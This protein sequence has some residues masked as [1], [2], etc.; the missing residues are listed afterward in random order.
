MAKKAQ[1]GEVNKS[2]AIRD[3]Y[4]Q[5]PQ[6]TVAEIVS[7]LAGK[8]IKVAPNLVYLVK[9]KIKGEKTHRRTVHR[10]AAQVATASGN[11]DAVATILKV[12]ALA[13]EVGGLAVL[14]ALVD[15][16]SA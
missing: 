4:K 13:N 8:G 2:A 9:G 5:N 7:T 11:S 10:N 12:K 3:L 15:A 6:A 16:L 14:K 1:N